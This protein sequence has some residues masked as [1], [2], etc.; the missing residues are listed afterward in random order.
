MLPVADRVTSLLEVDNLQSDRM[1]VRAQG[2][3][4]IVMRANTVVH[5]AAVASRHN[6]HKRIIL[7]TVDTR[8]LCCEDPGKDLFQRVSSLLSYMIP[9]WEEATV[10]WK[11]CSRRKG[12]A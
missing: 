10:A 9:G 8:V 4:G 3:G 7:E 11:P 12:L 2:K 5:V 1:A 6:V